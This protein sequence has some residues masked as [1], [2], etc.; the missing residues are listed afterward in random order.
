VP[1]LQEAKKPKHHTAAKKRI[2]QRGSVN[3]PLS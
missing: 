3:S 1:T 2:L